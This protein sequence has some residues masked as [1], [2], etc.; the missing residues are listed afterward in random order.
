MSRKKKTTKITVS[1]A[2]ERIPVE[3]IRH[4]SVNEAV[5]KLYSEM[6]KSEA[7]KAYRLLKK[8]WRA[9][10]RQLLHEKIANHYLNKLT[11]TL[12]GETTNE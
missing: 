8:C 6:E 11:K 4:T 2:G 7:K 3:I 5:I 12:K 1:E 10:R 9:E